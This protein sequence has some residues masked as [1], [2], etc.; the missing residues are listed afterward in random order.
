MNT[1]HKTKSD[2]TWKKVLYLDQGFPDN[3]VPESFLNDTKKNIFVRKYNYWSLVKNSVVLLQQ[4]CIVSLFILV[5][6]IMSKPSVCSPKTVVLFSFFTSTCGCALY[7]TIKPEPIKDYKLIDSNLKVLAL[8]IGFCYYFSP[9]LRTLTHTISTDTVYAMTTFAIFFH[10]LF[11]NYNQS[12]KFVVVAS[13][14]IS[15]NSAVFAAVCLASRLET[16]L[17]SFA[18]I[19][20]ALQLFGFWP[21]LQALA[22]KH[23]QNSFVV[24]VHAAQVV[25][26]AAWF[27]TSF[28][29]SLMFAITCLSVTF[30][31][32]LLLVSLQ[33]HKDNVHGPWDEA[34][35]DGNL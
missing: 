16:N 10:L 1:S 35:I 29:M 3:Y 9:L 21:F 18:T 14:S 32:P 6:W 12:D 19:T 27:F 22:W 2:K 25:L 17:H 8:I 28:T 11:H 7:Y 24:C 26:V 31:F 5:W 30:V 34:V 4:I 20:L 13:R 33:A 15:F 23:H